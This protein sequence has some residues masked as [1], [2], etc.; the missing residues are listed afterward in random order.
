MEVWEYGLVARDRIVGEQVTLI[1]YNN[2]GV[3]KIRS[4]LEQLIEGIARKG[5]KI[6]IIGDWNARI[7]KEHGRS[8]KYEGDKWYRNSQDSVLNWKGRRYVGYVS[9]DGL[10]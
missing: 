2:V 7:G 8:D 10:F 6:L 9:R 1:M 3:G 4:S 5:G